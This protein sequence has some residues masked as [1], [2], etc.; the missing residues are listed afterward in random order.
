VRFV[1]WHISWAHLLA[2]FLA[3][4]PF[5]TL[6]RLMAAHLAVNPGMSKW[7]QAMAFQF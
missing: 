3:V 5:G 2:S 7:G 1:H 4:L 6:W